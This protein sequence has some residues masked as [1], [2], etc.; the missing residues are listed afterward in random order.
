M[1]VR[2]PGES[3]AHIEVVDSAAQRLQALRDQID[4]GTVRL[5][6][7]IEQQDAGRVALDRPHAERV[8]RGSRNPR[9]EA[10]RLDAPSRRA[11]VLP[12]RF[13]EIVNDDH[14]DSEVLLDV[15]QLV[16]QPRTV[17]GRDI[18]I[19]LGSGVPAVEE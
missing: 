9:N 1:T 10:H 7:V 12:P 14:G 3:A 2:L 8:E 4:D 18:D 19:A 13:G 15:M 5:R 6:T 16:G 17:R 11:R